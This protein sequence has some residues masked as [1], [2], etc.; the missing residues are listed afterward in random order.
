M[1]ELELYEVYEAAARALINRRCA[2]AYLHDI[3]GT[4]QALFSAVE[5]LGRS[6]RSSSG[7]AARIDKACALAK[8]AIGN[9]ERATLEALQALTL[10]STDDSQTDL[11]ALVKEVVHFLRNEAA[12]KG[13]APTVAADDAMHILA[14]RAELQTMLV[15]LVS[16]AIDAT[17]AGQPLHVG[18]ARSGTD[19]VITVDSDAGYPGD[20]DPQ[21]ILHQTRATLRPR[22]LTRLFAARFL[23]AHGGRLEIDAAPPRGA[24]R[25]VYP[26]PVS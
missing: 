22:E 15:G 14:P 6:A 12:I 23:G 18:A 8:R 16:A 3:R 20:E 1:E 5:L 26:L 7:D 9:H 25:V 17:P 24:L 2:T 19:A 13:I 10:Q 11:G 21:S 4:M